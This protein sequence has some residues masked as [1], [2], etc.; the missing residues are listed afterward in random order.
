MRTILLSLVLILTG[1]LFG[2]GSATVVRVH[3]WLTR[4]LE[5]EALAGLRFANAWGGALDQLT[6]TL[7]LEGCTASDLSDF[8]LWIQ[9]N[10]VY[11]FYESSAV[12]LDSGIMTRTLTASDDGKTLTLTFSNPDYASVEMNRTKGWVYASDWLWLTATVNP[13][14]SREAAIRVE[15]SSE[16]LHLGENRYQVKNGSAARAH[17]IYPYRY[18]IRAYLPSNRIVGGGAG[19]DVFSDRPDLRVANLTELIQFS[20]TPTYQAASDS[21]VATLSSANQAVLARLKSL[22]DAYHP[23]QE[24]GC[25]ARIILGLIKGGDLTLA[26]TGGSA[27]TA[28]ALGHAAGSKYRAGFVSS[29]VSLLKTC[30]FDGLDI[31]WEYPNV[32]ATG[33]VVSNGEME[34]YG[35]LARDLAEAFFD[36]GLELSLCT[37]QSGWQIPGGEMLS[38]ADTIN[39]MAY[40]P[41]ETFLG[42]A[43]MSDGIAVCTARKVPK[44]RIVVGQAMYSNAGPHYGWDE[45]A[46]RLCTATT[47]PVTRWDADTLYFNWT[48]A[49]TGRSGTYANFTGP[50]TYRAK[51][52]RARMEDCGGVMSWGYYTDKLTWFGAERLSLAMH[53]AQTMWPHDYLWP[54]PPQRA[55]GF[56]ELDSESD[57]FWFQAN[58]K[59]NV[60]LTADIRFS[61]DPLPVT[62]FAHTLD[63]Q[64]HKLI[65]PSDVWICTFGTTALFKTITG[66]IRNLTVELEG[67]VLCRADRALNTSVAAD[68]TTLPSE[69]TTA[70]VLVGKMTSGSKLINVTVRLLPGSEVQGVLHTAAVAGEVW[71]AADKTVEL[72]QVHAD[73]ASTLRQ[74]ADNA[75]GHRFNPERG[76]LGGLLGWVGCPAAGGISVTDGSVRLASTALLDGETG[77]NGSVGGCIGN[78]NNANPAITGLRLSWEGGANL[79]CTSAPADAPTPMPWIA[80]YAFSS[81]AVLTGLSGK[82]IA[83]KTAFPWETWWLQSLAP[84][85][86]PGYR[87]LLR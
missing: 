31:D 38:S 58:P 13:A 36:A 55:D 8:R 5:R 46:N 49:S 14:I 6:F 50:S 73:I 42:N 80:S 3:P 18:R 48:N 15:V 51:V 53:Q 84:L 30:G 33:S 83:P 20:I 2:A 75:G 61:R 1:L 67:R 71:S 70:A 52:N 82:I 39:S 41:W 78:L 21:F 68:Q 87:F 66:R 47:D 62:T 28:T 57:W 86:H 24:N 11:G 54:T 59:H 60:C 85:S 74:R 17:R 77:T 32:L 76:A 40:G 45:L 7:Q 16:Q 72:N 69:E 44:R 12:R 26:S 29:L 23:L 22:R 9:P 79:R 34:K 4:G 64:G 56:Y 81:D 37:N 10:P 35:F 63:G 27:F 19:S 65:L 43:V 25:G